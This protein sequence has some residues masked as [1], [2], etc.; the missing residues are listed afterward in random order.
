MGT[1]NRAELLS[2]VSSIVL[3]AGSWCGA[4]TRGRN[5]SAKAGDH[6]IQR[7]V[8]LVVLHATVLDERRRFVPDPVDPLPPNKEIRFPALGEP[9]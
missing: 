8:N 9:S 2:Q 3:V 7:D 4:E 5:S 1:A 6:K